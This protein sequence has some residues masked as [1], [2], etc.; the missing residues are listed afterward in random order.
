MLKYFCEFLRCCPLFCLTPGRENSFLAP[1]IF[2]S[3]LIEDYFGSAPRCLLL[4]LF[5]AFRDLLR[6][7]LHEYGLTWTVVVFCREGLINC[8]FRWSWCQ[9]SHVDTG[10]GAHGLV[11]KL[12]HRN[13]SACMPA[14]SCLMCRFLAR[15]L[16]WSGH[17]ASRLCVKY[18]KLK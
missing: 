13:A 17:I 7:P 2:R 18:F 9:R 8:N 16:V 3:D 11:H 5:I 10:D 12:Q 1:S 15:F 4:T 14:K 6:L